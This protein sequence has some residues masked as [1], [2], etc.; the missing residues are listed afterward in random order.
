MCEVSQFGYAN[1]EAVGGR[2]LWVKWYRVLEHLRGAGPSVLFFQKVE[3][4]TH[5]LACSRAWPL[6]TEIRIVQNCEFLTIF[7]N[8]A[9]HLEPA[10]PG[11]NPS[12]QIAPYPQ[13][14]D[15]H[16]LNVWARVKTGITSKGRQLCR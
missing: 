10:L 2:T 11:R 15:L 13:S 9:L 8:H 1:D 6:M 3:Y 14:R 7:G 5:R 12:I 4:P 16:R